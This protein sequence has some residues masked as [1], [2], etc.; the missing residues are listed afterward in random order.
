MPG[1]EAPPAAAAALEPPGDDRLRE[2]PDLRRHTARGMLVNS[3]FDIG[4]IGLSALR[5]LVVAAFMTSRDYGIW[6]LLGL[7][8]WTALG[9]KAQFGV[10]DKYVQQSDL[11]QEQAFHRAFTVECIFACV[12]VPIVVGVVV[13]FEL[14]TGVSAVLA[15]GL[16]LLLLLPAAVLQFPM[17]TFYR[18]MDYRRQR[19]LAA[20]DPVISTVVTVALAAAGAGYWSFVVGLLAGAW[21]GAAAALVANPYR[22]RL[23]YERGVLR[24]YLAFSAPL[25]VTGLSVIAMFQVIYLVGAAPLGVAGLGAY[26]LAGNLL[27]FTDQADSIITTTLYPAVC[28][29]R[30]R[31]ELLTEVFVKSNRLSLMWAV[32]FGTGLSLFASDLVRF[33][34]G[35]RWHLAVPLLEIMGLMTAVNHVGYNWAAFFKAQGRTGPIAVV[36]LITVVTVIGSAIPL[37]YADQLVGLGIAFAIGEAVSLI[38]RGILLARFFAGFRIL[39]QLRRA[40]AP[41]AIAAAPVLLVRLLAGPEGSLAAAVALF[42]LYVALTIVATTVLERPLLREAVGYLARRGV[43][44]A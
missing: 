31:V 19:V 23:H 29:V 34:L 39:G 7:A 11:D 22:L 9:L 16:A 41:T 15:P 10:N 18:R 21:A 20:V 1:T 44:A 4:L 6:G 37:M 42:L 14:V 26:T 36:S 3:A 40:F 8:L 5:G 43:Q 28:A 2:I 25:L 17:W 38:T 12:M 30:D 24:G 35:A 13:L 27:Q 32:P 33:V